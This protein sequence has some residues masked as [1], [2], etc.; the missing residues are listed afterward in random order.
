LAELDREP[1][2]ARQL[3]QELSDRGQLGRTKVGP[4]LNENRAELGSQLA[5]AVEELGSRVIDVSQ[6][7]FVRDLLGSFSAKTKS[8]GVR[9]AQPCT[10][11]TAG[12]A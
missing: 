6:A 10:V 5:R 11:L 3:W 1:H 2:V 4:E 8:S 7:A 9:C 12:V